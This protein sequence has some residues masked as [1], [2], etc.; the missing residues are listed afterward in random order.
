LGHEVARRHNENKIV[1]NSILAHHEDVEA[2]TPYAII[3][4]AADAI[5]GAR[6]GARRETLENYVKRLE[7][8]EK[9]A[10]GFPGVEKSY[11]IQAGR[12]VRVIVEPADIDDKGSNI[13]ASE[14]AQKIQDE[15]EYPGQI[16]VT[17]IRETRAIE[18]AK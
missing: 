11:A 8:L 15:L 3:T 1:L 13:V 4:K 2:E 7:K 6:P 12:E 9:V 16:K 14:I 10:D 18:Y 17:V 5:S